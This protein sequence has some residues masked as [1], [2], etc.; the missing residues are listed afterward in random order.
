MPAPSSSIVTLYIFRLSAAW[1]GAPSASAASRTGTAAQTASSHVTPPWS[2]TSRS[3]G[4][5]HP[6]AALSTA[7]S[8]TFVHASEGEQL[9]AEDRHRRVAAGDAADAAAAPRAR[10]AE[11]HV[12]DRRSRSP[13]ARLV[14]VLGERPREVAVEDV[15]ARE[16][17]LV[18]Q[19]ERGLGLQARAR[20]RAPR[21][22]Q[23]SIGSASTRVERPQ[24]GRRAPRGVPPRG[25]ARTAGRA[26]AARTASACGRRTPGAEDGRVGQR[27]AVDLARQQR[28][29]AAGGASRVR[30]LEL[31]VALVDVERAGE[32]LLGRAP[33]RR[34]AAAAATAAC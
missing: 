29:H 24:R 11:L 25:R 20:R 27:V 32:R 12:G 9:P 21:S 2:K 4:V 18:L 13:S 10:A 17:Q 34:A 30:G 7:R 14:L 26:C 19:V 1:A 8:W 3:G 23:S 33:S 22:R 6:R 15:A 5:K 31:R 28:R 16:R